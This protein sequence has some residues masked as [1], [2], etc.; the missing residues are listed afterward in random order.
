[1]PQSAA[2][3]EISP[4]AESSELGAPCLGTFLRKKEGLRKSLFF[5]RPVRLV[6]CMGRVG[7]RKAEDAAVA[8]AGGALGIGRRRATI[9]MTP[10]IGRRGA[11]ARPIGHYRLGFSAQH[12]LNERLAIIDY[13]HTVLSLAHVVPHSRPKLASGDGVVV[14]AK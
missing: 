10:R 14:V 11:V 3:R 5:L 1:M 13:G 2:V 12:C 9:L 6:Y 7:V 4:T 8:K